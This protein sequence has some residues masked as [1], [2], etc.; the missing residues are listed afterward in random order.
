MAVTVPGTAKAPA[1]DE[2]A[3]L[4]RMVRVMFPHAKFPEGPY[5]RTA[6][7]I[8]D[9]GSDDARLRAQLIQGLRDLD[10]TGPKPFRELD[11]A[12]ALELLEGIQGSEFFQSV[13]GAVI[14]SLYDDPEVWALLGY[15]GDATQNGGYAGN[16]DDLDWLPDPRVEEAS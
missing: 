5:E 7:A 9:S 12:A 2:L 1:V 4:T 14:T 13:R 3:Q 6:Q 8:L 11:D 10:A 15:E 16:F